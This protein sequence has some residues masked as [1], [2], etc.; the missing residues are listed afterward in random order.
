MILS[1]QSPRREVMKHERMP[2]TL[3]RMR[4][5]LFLL[6]SSALVACEADNCDESDYACDGGFDQRESVG[7]ADRGSVPSGPSHEELCEEACGEVDECLSLDPTL[8]EVA[9]SG[10]VFDTCFDMCDRDLISPERLLDSSCD[11]RFRR[12]KGASEAFEALCVP[13]EEPE[14]MR[15]VNVPCSVEGEDGVC[16]PTA[17]CAVGEGL[18]FPGACPGNDDN[19]C[20]VLFA[21]DDYRGEC[22]G[23][24]A[25]ASR[26][27]ESRPGLCPGTSDVQCCVGLE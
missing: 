7:P 23:V 13:G 20:C 24:S 17:Q 11:D 26:D 25:C 5:S 18:S 9:E 15:S 22:M 4:V 6:V 21:C 16:L 1:D 2:H 3:L 8:C 19:Q 27:G 14:P 10:A 12:L